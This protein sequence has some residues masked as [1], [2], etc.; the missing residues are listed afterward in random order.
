[1]V[2]I[3][4]HDFELAVRDALDEVPPQLL[5]LLDNVAF[6]VED[7]PGPEH[8]DPGLSDE[9]NAELLGIYLGTPLTERDGGWAGSLPDRIVLFR[10]PLTRMCEDLDD[11]REE[12]AIT[13]VHEAGHHVGIDEQRLHELGWG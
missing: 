3:S 8:A 12:I 13:I 11:L 2:E 7:E 10:G 9:D 6:F 5:D 1:M 4:E